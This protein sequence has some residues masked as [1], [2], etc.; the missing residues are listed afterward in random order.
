MIA[1]VIKLINLAPS[2]NYS[3]QLERIVFGPPRS[4]LR[5]SG[6]IRG[7]IDLA[8]NNSAQAHREYYI[9][10]DEP[11]ALIEGEDLSMYFTDYILMRMAQFLSERYQVLDENILKCYSKIFFHILQIYPLINKEINQ[12]NLYCRLLTYQDI[13][14][15]KRDRFQN[16]HVHGPEMTVKSSINCIRSSTNGLKSSANGL[17][18]SINGLLAIPML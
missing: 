18:S 1:I 3:R 17:K 15:L 13:L 16:G 5:S 7:P 6:D 12:S 8:A 11:I 10:Y 9:S 4:N 14:K 2:Q